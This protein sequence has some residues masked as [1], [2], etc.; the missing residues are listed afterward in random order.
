MRCFGRVRDGASPVGFALA[1][2]IAGV[3]LPA[4]IRAI[5][6]IGT[7]SAVSFSQY[8]KACTKV[9]E[10]IP[11]ATTVRHTTMTTATDPPRTA[12]PW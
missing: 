7:A 6:T 5:N 4:S 10:R 8:W 3:P 9:M 2:A 1:S 11:P 12:G